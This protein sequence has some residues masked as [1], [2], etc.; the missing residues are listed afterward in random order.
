MQTEQQKNQAGLGMRLGV[1]CF[2]YSCMCIANDTYYVWTNL[3]LQ[4]YVQTNTPTDVLL[5]AELFY[6]FIPTLFP[7]YLSFC[8]PYILLQF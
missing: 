8:Y 6:A 3:H 2:Y 4:H 5:Y 7:Y 1:L